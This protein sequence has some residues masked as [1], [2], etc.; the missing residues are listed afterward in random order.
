[1][2]LTSEQITQASFK[3]RFRG[4]DATEVADFLKL[5]SARLDELEH[6]LREQNEKIVAQGRDL[7]LAVDDKKSFEDVIGVYKET[8]KTLKSDQ[9]ETAQRMLTL[10]EELNRQKRDNQALQSERDRL[11]TEL[12]QVRTSLSEA[13]SK[14]RMSQAALE[15]LRQQFAALEGEKKELYAE[16]AQARKALD[17][18]LQRSQDLIEKSRQQADRLVSAAREEVDQ[19]R[20]QASLE[21]VQLREDIER[22]RG[23]RS[24]FHRDLRNLLKTHL[25]GMADLPEEKQQAGPDD[26]DDLFQKIDFAE[27]AEFEEGEGEQEISSQ[28]R[29]EPESSEVSEERLKSTLK[30]GGIAYLSDE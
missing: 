17:D 28:K 10:E 18:T 14:A 15:E 12:S 6:Q 16:A 29:R 3:T 11:K 13:E 9:E 26:Y 27:L 19:L 7:E 23:Q 22:L 21:L 1:M 25:A 24:Q 20:S 8:I 5:V 2:A 4:V 30:D